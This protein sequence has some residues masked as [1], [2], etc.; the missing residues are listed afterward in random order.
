MEDD[1]I[2][3]FS[4]KGSK[5]LAINCNSAL[6]LVVITTSQGQFTVDHEQECCESVQLYRTDICAASINEEII[7]ASEE[8]LNEHP[9]FYKPSEYEES[10]TW[11]VYKIHTKS[12]ISTL[13]FLGESNGYYCES[14][15][16]SKI[17]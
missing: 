12:G 2:Q 17:A 9:P 6:R 16:V 15:S 13:Y 14:T 10:F 1:R 8:F 11:S 7:E 3:F 5:L 4:L